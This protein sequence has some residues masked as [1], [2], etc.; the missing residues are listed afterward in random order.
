MDRVV[1]GELED[2]KDPALFELVVNL[3]SRSPLVGI[4][5]LS[6]AARFDNDRTTFNLFG[7]CLVVTDSLPTSV[8]QVDHHREDDDAA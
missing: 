7:I 2:T 4:D 5:F 1:K 3:S 8:D 6:T